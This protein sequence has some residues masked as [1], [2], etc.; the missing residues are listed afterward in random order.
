MPALPPKADIRRGYCDVCFGLIA[1]ITAIQLAGSLP[2]KFRRLC[3]IGRRTGRRVSQFVA[4]KP[5]LSLLVGSF[6]V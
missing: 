2:Y 3:G 6:P 1:E 4:H 5:E